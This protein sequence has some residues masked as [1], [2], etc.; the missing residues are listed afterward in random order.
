MISHDLVKMYCAVGSLSRESAVAR[1]Y[2]HELVPEPLRHQSSVKKKLRGMCQR[3]IPKLVHVLSGR[4]LVQLGS[5]EV[6]WARRREG[7]SKSARHR[8]NQLRSDRRCG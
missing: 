4:A 2:K 8:Q 6:N 7:F 5:P 3:D 1:A